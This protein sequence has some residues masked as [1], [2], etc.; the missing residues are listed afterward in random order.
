MVSC[1]AFPLALLDTVPLLWNHVLSP[2]IFC[3]K[4]LTARYPS[5]FLKLTGCA[6]GSILLLPCMDASAFL[7]LLFRS[8]IGPFVSVSAFERRDR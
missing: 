8:G 7:S 1:R 2:S 4:S 6:L 3:R 5:A